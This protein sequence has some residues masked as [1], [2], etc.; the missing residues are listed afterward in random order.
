M[1]KG[2]WLKL[3]IYPLFPAFRGSSSVET[4]RVFRSPRQ[5]MCFLSR[6]LFLCIL[7]KQRGSCRFTFTLHSLLAYLPAKWTEKWRSFRHN[8][9]L[10]YHLTYVM[11]FPLNKHPNHI[12]T[13]NVVTIQNTCYIFQKFPKSNLS[14]KWSTYHFPFRAWQLNVRFYLLNQMTF[15]L[16]SC[17]IHPLHA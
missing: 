5:N 8:R 3:W 11:Q 4:V 2:L 17:Y 15:V 6:L 10:I 7:R 9:H 12:L 13:H 16:G 1:C 14:G